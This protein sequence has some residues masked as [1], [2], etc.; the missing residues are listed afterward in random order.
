M[1]RITGVSSGSGKILKAAVAEYDTF[2][3]FSLSFLC[4]PV[5]E[6]TGSYLLELHR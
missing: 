3:H 6:G 4:N 5:A 2:A 1:T